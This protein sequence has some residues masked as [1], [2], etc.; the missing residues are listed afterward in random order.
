L[1]AA[2]WLQ[3]KFLYLPGSKTTF[4][5]IACNTAANPPTLDVWGVTNDSQGHRLHLFTFAD[6]VKAGAKGLFIKVEPLGSVFASVDANNHFV[7]Q[8]FGGPAGA[9]G[10]KDFRKSFTCD[11]KR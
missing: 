2:P 9:T 5:D 10:D 3:D 4:T 1:P 11:F 6:L 8:W 7:V